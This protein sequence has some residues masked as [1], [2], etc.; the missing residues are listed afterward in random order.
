MA[1]NAQLL[2]N[3]YAESFELELGFRYRYESYEIASLSVDL[4]GSERAAVLEGT[5]RYKGLIERDC[6]H[7]AA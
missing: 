5:R 4:A 3:K 1:L 7:V 6:D 2:D